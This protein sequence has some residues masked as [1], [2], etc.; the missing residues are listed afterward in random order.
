MIVLPLL[1]AVPSVLAVGSF[2][3][4]SSSASSLTLHP[5]DEVR[6]EWRQVPDYDLL[7]LGYYSYS[8][9]TVTWLISNSNGHPTSYDWTARPDLDG[10][11]TWQNDTFN[12]YC[13]N[14]TNFGLPFQSSPFHFQSKEADTASTTTSS[15]SSPTSVDVAT[16]PTTTQATPQSLTSQSQGG[17][18]TGAKAGIGAGI[19]V[20]VLLIVVLG[21]LAFRRRD[22]SRGNGLG[23]SYQHT[24]DDHVVPGGNNRTYR[25]GGY[26]QFGGTPDTASTGIV[27][28]SPPV[29]M[30]GTPM[31]TVELD[32]G[33]H[34]GTQGGVYN[35]KFRAA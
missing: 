25:A 34:H 13:V 6:I 31:G 1:L 30:D 32:G 3:N 19:A 33:N 29:E 14:G 16:T 10:F 27:E 11:T 2:V 26:P 17:L 4:P 18:S 23:G 24:N 5:G 15:S 22:E 28:K 12:L 21:F 35:G 8:N 20:A 7:S 9:R